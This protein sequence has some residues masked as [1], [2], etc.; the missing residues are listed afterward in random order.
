MKKKDKKKNTYKYDNKRFILVFTMMFCLVISMSTYWMY[1][2]KHKYGKNYFDNKIISYK[3][4]DYVD[5]D[6]N[7]VYLKNIDK[8]IINTFINKQK[9]VLKNNVIDMSVTKGIYK[10]ILSIVHYHSFQIDKKDST[11]KRNITAP[12]KRIKEIQTRILKLLQN[13]ERPIWLISGEK[14]KCYIDNGKSHLNSNYFLT[15]DIKKFYDN[16]SRE[17][18]FLF[19]KNRLMMAGDLAGLCTDIVTYDGGIPTGCPTSQIIAY[20]AYESMFNEI[21]SVACKYGCEY[22][23]YVDD[24]TFSAKEPFDINRMKNE[25]DCILRKYGHK[26]KYKKVKY[27]SKGKSVPITGTIVTGQHELKVPNR[28]QKRVYD[29]FQELKYLG[30][31]EL[32][33]IEI[34]KLNSLKGRILASRNI[35]EGKFP[36]INRLTNLIG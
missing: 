27:Y 13:V 9:E 35:E 24:M 21:Y 32:S 30:G 17:Y 33:D 36:E 11:E 26:P 34:R 4:S 25:V 18:V 1:A 22:T 6:G 20:Y 31:K 16:C 2:Y 14:G 10:D 28:L 7:Y 29:D 12:D 23:V 19:F 5:T 8:E 15:M 3:L